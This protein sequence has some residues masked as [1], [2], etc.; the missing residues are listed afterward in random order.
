VIL[1]FCW[2]LLLVRRSVLA[3]VHWSR[4]LPKIVYF[5]SAMQFFESI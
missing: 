3:L 5:V 4:E 2:R 1:F